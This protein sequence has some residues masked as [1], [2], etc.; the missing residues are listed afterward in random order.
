MGFSGGF[1]R[2]VLAGLLLAG[3]YGVAWL[4]LYEVGQWG[5]MVSGAWPWFVP[6]ALRLAALMVAP[7]PCLP[8]LIAVELMIGVVWAHWFLVAPTAIV[9]LRHLALPLGAALVALAWR[10]AP[11]G[12][13]RVD[14]VRGAL[15]LM[16]AMVL[17]PAASALSG[18]LAAA[19][20]VPSVGVSP[21]LFAVY[22]V[23]ELAAILSFTPAL[24]VL[25]GRVAA[26]E[27]AERP[28]SDTLMHASG[29]LAVGFAVLVA[30]ELWGL[31]AEAAVGAFLL[32]VA[33]SALRFGLSGAALAVAAVNTMLVLSAQAGPPVQGGGLI[34]VAGVGLTLGAAARRLAP[35]WLGRAAPPLLLLLPTLLPTVPAAPAHAQERPW[36]VV[37]LAFESDDYDSFRAFR[38]RLAEDGHPVEFFARSLGGDVRRMPAMIEEIRA[39]G[40]DLVYTQNTT[41]ATA[42]VGRGVTPD[43]A[44][45]LTE[46]PVVFS[47]VSDPVGAGLVAAPAGPAEPLLSRR[48]VT[49]TI[50]VLDEATLLRSLLA[51]RPSDRV[52]VLYD[53]VEPSNL[54][55]VEDLKL[56]ASGLR[57]TLDFVPFRTDRAPA[58]PEGLARLLA[59]I[60]ARRP[61]MLYLI[62][63]AGLAPHVRPLFR[64]AQRLRLPTFC[65]LETFIDA[66]CMAGVMPPLGEL[67]RQTADMAL[68]ILRGR[69]KPGDIPIAGP[70]RFSYFVNLPVAQRLG[71]FPSIQILTFARL[72]DRP[73][74]DSR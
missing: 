42:L 5:V 17:A 38:R 13:G 15:R 73:P 61:D 67:G 16:A 27:V 58:T 10:L 24:L 47:F 4:A 23:E 46:V 30:G 22:F 72:V 3:G 56:A 74:A 32:P 40:A 70:Q 35:G 19:A 59:D 55:R 64:E 57:T 26:P 62:P 48:N 68:A 28:L 14:G 33:W 11:G 63:S 71:A 2:G 60:A 12:G 34:L 37:T 8:L 18:T 29:V 43:P 51:Y 31:S 6:A 65:A 25:V 7:L 49:G 69:A 45:F 52:T 36:R 39:L 44:R 54:W 53:G 50:H 66:G 9:L 21:G 20:E 41:M 1:V